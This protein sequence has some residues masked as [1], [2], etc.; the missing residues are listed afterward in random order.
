MAT[1]RKVRKVNKKQTMVS[2]KTAN[3]GEMFA[4]PAVYTNKIYIT[5]TQDALIRIMFAELS[6]AGEQVR[7]SVI[8]SRMNLENVHNIIGQVLEQSK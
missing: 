6:E 2:V 4:L 1:R 8:M 5:G 7:A 3:L